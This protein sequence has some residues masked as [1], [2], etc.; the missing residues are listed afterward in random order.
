MPDASLPL[1]PGAVSFAAC[2]RSGVRPHEDAVL[3]HA[4]GR[5]P[6]RGWCQTVTKGPHALRHISRWWIVAA[7]AITAF[8]LGYVGLDH[9]AVQ[10]RVPWPSHA[11]YTL[12]LFKSSVPTP[13]RSAPLGVAV[14]LAPLTAAYAAF[15]ALAEI[16]STQWRALRVRR[17]AAGHVVVCGL[18]DT[19]LRVAREF[20]LSGSRVVGIEVA[21]SPSTVD[22]CRE[23]GIVL[24]RGDATDALT[25]RRAAVQRARHLVAVCGSDGANASVALGVQ[26][27]AERRSRPVRCIVQIDEDQLCALLEQA[28]LSDVAVRTVSLEFF[29]LHRAGA[30]ALLDSVQSEAGSVDLNHVMVVGRGAIASEVTAEIARRWTIEPADSRRLELVTPSAAQLSA[31]LRARFGGLEGICDVKHHPLDP[32]A[33]DSNLSGFE[34]TERSVVLVC[35]DDDSAGLQATLRLE[36]ELP[37]GTRIFLCVTGLTS[38]EVLLSLAN[39][40]ILPNVHIFPVLDR[41]C[42]PQVILNSQRE[43]IAQAIHANY[44][45]EER[46]RGVRGDNDPALAS[47]EDLPESL[48]QANRDQAADIGHKLAAIGRRVINTSSRVQ[49]SPDFT[50]DEVE[51]MA[52]LEH[53]R[54]V[55]DRVADGW[56]IGPLRDLEAKTHPSLVPWDELDNDDRARDREAVAAIPTLLARA[57]YA[58]APERTGRNQRSTPGPG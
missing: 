5:I 53:E 21:P 33:P 10:R 32:A 18:G 4:A 46:S 8:V 23:V 12:L 20:A 28:A 31:A 47:W 40:D 54:W 49:P 19:G 38:A 42:R 37:R 44:V 25:L 58:I 52:R 15:R 56:R 24:I 36:R 22:V 16:F 29:N 14:W 1:R 48:R 41:V 51:T 35:D 11:W 3:R 55:A 57:G 9:F 26:G 27:L 7:S 6:A 34:V 50:V 17:F 39:P 13:P 45:R 2:Y 43:L 30:R